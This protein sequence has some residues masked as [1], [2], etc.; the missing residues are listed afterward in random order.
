MCECSILRARASRPSGRCAEYFPAEEQA[1]APSH[2]RRRAVRLISSLIC[3]FS[4]RRLFSYDAYSLISQQITISQAIINSKATAANEI[5]R[6]LTECLVWARPVYI[7]LPT[8]IVH[9]RIPATR[10]KTPLNI[11]PPANE[12][13][14]EAFVLDE[15]VKL[16]EGVT[17]GEEKGEVVVLVD[18]CAIRHCVKEEVD[19]LVRKTGFPVF[20]APMGKTALDESYERYG[21]VSATLCE[22]MLI[23][24]AL[25]LDLHWR[26]QSSRSE[27]EH[28]KCQSH[29][30]C[31]CTQ[32]RFQYWQLFVPYPEESDHRG[33]SDDHRYTT[34]SFN[35]DLSFIRIT[36]KCNTRSTMELG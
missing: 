31:R 23:A 27:E 17:K 19:E 35:F 9:E 10:L 14:I 30:V 33:E 22:D 36:P 25:R 32:E 21:G 6:V 34:I 2:T 8:D 13:E 3:S 20:A 28:R 16:V 26:D 4:T 15:I 29:L 5:D 24:Y 1:H 12:P 11:V 18:G 7:M